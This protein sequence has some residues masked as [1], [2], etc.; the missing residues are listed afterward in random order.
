[1]KTIYKAIRDAL[2]TD[3][4]VTN[5]VSAPNIT[6]GVKGKEIASFPAITILRIDEGDEKFLDG[7][8]LKEA[9]FQISI[10]SETSFENVLDIEEAIE[11]VMVDS[12]TTLTDAGVVDVTKTS[13]REFFKDVWHGIMEYRIVYM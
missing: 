4:T 10:F 6:A 13:S 7:S 3:V 2:V 8:K 12:N 5:L 1:M 9:P 11:S